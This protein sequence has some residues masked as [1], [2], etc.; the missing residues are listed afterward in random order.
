LLNKETVPQNWP[1][2]LRLESRVTEGM[3]GESS[4]PAKS[5]QARRAK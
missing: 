3:R 4:R 5:Q 1:K 2:I